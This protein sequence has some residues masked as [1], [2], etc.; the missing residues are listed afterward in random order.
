MT[1]TIPVIHKHTFLDL[2]CEEERHIAS[3]GPT[4]EAALK[5]CSNP[6]RLR[7]VSS[8]EIPYKHSAMAV[9]LAELLPGDWSV[10]PQ[11]DEY[12]DC[13]WDLKRADGLKLYLSAP[14]YGHKEK[15]TIGLSTPRHE[16]RYVEAYE[17]NQR[18]SLQSIGIGVS[19]TVQQMASD[20]VRRFLSE[21]ERV[22]LLYVA[23]IE[24]VKEAKNAQQSSMEAVCKALK[25]EVPRPGQSGSERLTGW[26]NGGTFEVF[27]GGNVSFSLSSVSPEKAAEIA[28]ALRSIL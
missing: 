10:I 3:F 18:V 25:I 24:R 6:D 7:Y 16:G 15:W 4:M 23:T 27:P 2:D 9:A 13:N 1:T 21:A 20:I 17:K 19:K 28:F 5:H 26:F 12:V 8:E 11:S 22:H 14:C